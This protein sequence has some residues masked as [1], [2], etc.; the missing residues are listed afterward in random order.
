MTKLQCSESN[1]LI[2]LSTLIQDLYRPQNQRKNVNS[3]NLSSALLSKIKVEKKQ[4]KSMLC[5][6]LENA[7]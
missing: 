5:R 1:L 2:F 3:E 6:H 7:S 4:N